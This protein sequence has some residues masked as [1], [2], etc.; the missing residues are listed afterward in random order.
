MLRSARLVIA[1]FAL[2]TL[3][4]AP[5]VVADDN[6]A[7]SNVVTE[8]IDWLTG[9]LGGDTPTEGDGEYQPV[10]LPGG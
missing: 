2:A 8:I 5:I 7:A 6:S 3:F 4:S 1:L 10:F 9:V